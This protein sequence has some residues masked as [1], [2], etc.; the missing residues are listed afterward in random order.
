M[1]TTLSKLVDRSRFN[2]AVKQLTDEEYTTFMVKI[3]KKFDRDSICNL[4]SGQSSQ[5]NDNHTFIKQYNEIINN[6]ILDRSIDN[7]DSTNIID[8]NRVMDDLPS[9]IIGEIGSYLDS[10]ILLATSEKA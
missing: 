5:L 1:T 6:I 9:P 2:Q 3:S 10:F 4:L 7:G 8:T